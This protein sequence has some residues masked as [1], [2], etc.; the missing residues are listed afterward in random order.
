[1]GGTGA[2]VDAIE[3]LMIEQ[4]I[5]IRL[6]TTVTA[7]ATE[8]GKIQSVAIEGND[9]HQ[10]RLRADW[11]ISNADPVHLYKSLLPKASVNWAARVKADRWRKSMGLFVL[12]FWDQASIP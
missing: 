6:N 5:E 11:V 1:M 10:E 4:G 2:L 7:L 3:A 8:D 9:G 12:F